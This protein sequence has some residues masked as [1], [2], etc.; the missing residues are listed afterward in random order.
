MFVSLCYVLAT[1]TPSIFNVW[2][3]LCLFYGPCLDKWRYEQSYYTIYIPGGTQENKEMEL[4]AITSENMC[5]LNIVII[6]RRTCFIDIFLRTRFKQNWIGFSSETHNLWL[7][8]YFN[9]NQ[10]SVN[11]QFCI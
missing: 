11:F 4:F 3:R 6:Y 2:H 1:V 10:G 9:G 5:V 7:S 8:G